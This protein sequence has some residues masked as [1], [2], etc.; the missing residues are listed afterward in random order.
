MKT[1]GSDMKMPLELIEAG[2]PAWSRDGSED[3]RYAWQRG[4]NDLYVM[5]A[6]GRNQVRPT[7]N[8][9]GCIEPD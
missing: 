8:C 2:Y 6:N 3:C 1:D 4:N 5:D 9:G 7:R